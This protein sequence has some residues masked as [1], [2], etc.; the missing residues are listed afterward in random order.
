MQG[1][2]VSS[3]IWEIRSCKMWQKKKKRKKERKEGR[4]GGRE[5]ERKKEKN[6]IFLRTRPYWVFCLHRDPSTTLLVLYQRPLSVIKAVR[7]M[8]GCRRGWCVG[9][10]FTE[11][12]F[13]AGLRFRVLISFACTTGNLWLPQLSLE[14]GMATHSSILAWRIPW[15]EEPGGLQ[16][17]GLQRVRHDWMTNTH[18]FL[19]RSLS[20]M[21]CECLP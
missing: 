14:K 16:S 20:W 12:S 11:A 13:F 10:L 5:G 18:S 17:L 4:N 7:R 15:T 8:I 2:W 6:V 1:A 21:G 3:L 19:L 9:G